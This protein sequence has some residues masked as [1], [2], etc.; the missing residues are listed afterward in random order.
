VGNRRAQY[1]PPAGGQRLAAGGGDRARPGQPS[2]S[3][4]GPDSNPF[5]TPHPGPCPAAAARRPPARPPPPPLL[6]RRGGRRARPRRP[7]P[8]GRR[9]PM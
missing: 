6:R 5:L 4:H 3:T 8:G 1:L 9:P 2:P 7:Q